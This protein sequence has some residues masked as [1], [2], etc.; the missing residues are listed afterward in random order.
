M[1]LG[2]ALMHLEISPSTSS[3][4]ALKAYKDLIRVWHPDN[5]ESKP[6]LRDRATAKTKALNQAWEVYQHEAMGERTEHRSPRRVPWTALALVF[7]FVAGTCLGILAYLQATDAF[8]PDLRLAKVLTEMSWRTN[9]GLP[10][11]LDDDTKLTAS[12]AGPGRRFTYVYHI[13]HYTRNQV[14]DGYFETV[15]QGIKESIRNNLGQDKNLKFFSQNNIVL[16]YSFK[17]QTG[18]DIVT[19]EITPEEYQAP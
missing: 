1:T 18:A 7:L 8:E 6:D 19:L 11:E 10:L 2:E 14:G 12:F 5:F 9:Q 4:E 13:L 17:D 15:R 16:N 3:D